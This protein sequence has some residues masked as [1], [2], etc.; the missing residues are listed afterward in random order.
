VIAVADLFTWRDESEA[1]QRVAQ[2]EAARAE[3]ERRVRCAPHGEVQVRRERLAQATREALAA[4][5]AL[6][7][8]QRRERYP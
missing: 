6:A 5:T 4:E 7:R 2:A 3:A 8:I 1:A